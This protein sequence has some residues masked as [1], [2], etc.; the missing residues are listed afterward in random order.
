VPLERRSFVRRESV[1]QVLGYEPDERLAL[2]FRLLCHP[3]PLVC[4][5][6]A[7]VTDPKDLRGMG[8]RDFDRVVVALQ[9]GPHSGTRPVQQHALVALTDLERVA[10]LGRGPSLDV[11]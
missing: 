6:G 4:E 3:Q 5:R 2:Q 11:P 9:G 10:D 7:R 8:D 1:V